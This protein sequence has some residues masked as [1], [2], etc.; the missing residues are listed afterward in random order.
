MSDVTVDRMEAVLRVRD[1]RKSFRS[2]TRTF[3][4]LNGVTFDVAAGESLSIRGESGSGK[5]TLLNI[6]AGL[7]TADAGGVLW[8]DLKAHEQSPRALCRWR[9]DFVGMV[10]QAYYLIPE[11]NA[12]ENVLFPARLRGGISRTERERAAALL[13]AVGLSGRMESLP[14]TLSG[15]ER[16]RVA[17]ARGLMNRPA[18]L[19]ADEPTGN[20]DE[21]TSA[22]IMSLLLD[23]CRGESAALVLVTHS[24]VYA[25]QTSRTA[26]LHE[27]RLE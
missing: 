7:E 26:L 15:G 21:R 6:V 17:I 19:L 4:I 25:A 8:K 27:G 2:G 13:E 5:T 10:F 11:M 3:E 1:V 14:A 18:L 23:V 12:L 9:R 24:P 20:L 16:Q 22:A